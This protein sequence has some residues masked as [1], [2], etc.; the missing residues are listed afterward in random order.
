LSFAY[1]SQT[2]SIKEEEYFKT[3]DSVQI[4]YIG[5]FPIRVVAY[6]QN[7]IS[8]IAAKT[9]TS[10]RREQVYLASDV[11]T[12]ADALQL[13]NSL[14]TQFEEAT[15]EIKFWL[16]SAQLE[17]LGMVLDHTEILTQITFALP[18]IHIVGDY[19]ITE[20]T[21]SPFSADASVYKIELTLRDRNYLKSYAETISDLYRDINQLYIRQ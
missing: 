11:T 7:K 5:M 9:G 14:L 10:G 12:T 19:I 2:V 3:G 8:E 6:N 4:D 13:A 21:L 16:T 18:E 17:S 1:D 15:G 20:R